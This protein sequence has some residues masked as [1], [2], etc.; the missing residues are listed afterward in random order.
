MF[1]FSGAPQLQANFGEGRFATSDLS[2]AVNDAGGNGTFEYDPLGFYSIC[3][4][5]LKDYG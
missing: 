4:K 1:G 5:N 2:S 3:T